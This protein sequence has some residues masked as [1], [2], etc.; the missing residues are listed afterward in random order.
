MSI[1]FGLAA[2]PDSQRVAHNMRMILFGNFGHDRMPAVHETLI[3]AAHGLRDSFV[4]RM[5][6]EGV[7]EIVLST[8]FNDSYFLSGHLIL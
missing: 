4:A 1:R 7:G 8:D 2:E 3:R 5:F 6:C